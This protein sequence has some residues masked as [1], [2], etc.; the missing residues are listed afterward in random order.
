ML[1]RQVAIWEVFPLEKIFANVLNL[2]LDIVE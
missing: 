1:Y 2:K